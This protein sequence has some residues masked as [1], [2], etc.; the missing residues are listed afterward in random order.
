LDPEVYDSVKQA[1]T[2]DRRTTSSMAE[3]L[4]RDA[5]KTHKVKRNYGGIPTL[6]S[7]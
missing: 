4:L 2:E 7:E 6:I 1:A 5:L 3:I